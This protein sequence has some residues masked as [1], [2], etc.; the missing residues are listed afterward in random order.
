MKLFQNK[1]AEKL[2]IVSRKLKKKN[3]VL[4]AASLFS[5]TVFYMVVAVLVIILGI[6]AFVCFSASSDMYNID[7]ISN[8]TYEYD[9]IMVLG[10]GVNGYSPSLMLSDRLDTAIALYKKGVAK[11]LLMSGDHGDLYY[12]EV[13]VMKAY[14]MEKG[15]PSEDIFM[16]HAGFST[17][18]SLL[19]AKE[20]FG[21]KK[22]V[23]VTQEYHLYRTVYVG[24]SL[25]LE[26][27]GIASEGD[28]YSG[29]TYRDFRE[30]FARDKDFINTL[31]KIEDIAPFDSNKINIRGNGNVTNDKAFYNIA[32]KKGL[33]VF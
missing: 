4:R 7:E 19:R 12:N 2:N 17:Y 24:K 16:D 15:V 13:G 18:E 28:N 20:I 11:K 8:D 29:Q 30:I 9:C 27:T 23:A 22:L 1:R 14:A 21:V 3:K 5:K 32:E 25:E 31:I 33:E 26:I 6:N 10:C